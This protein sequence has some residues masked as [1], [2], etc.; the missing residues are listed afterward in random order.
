MVNIHV[1]RS[2]LTVDSDSARN[3]VEGWHGG[4][5]AAQTGKNIRSRKK[6]KEAEANKA[7]MAVSRYL[8]AGYGCF[9]TKYPAVRNF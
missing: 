5:E 4:R 3:K 6:R 8:A 9:K 2:R 7:K 1:R